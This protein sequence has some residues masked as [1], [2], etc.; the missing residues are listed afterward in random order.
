[1]AVARLAAD[2]LTLRE[3]CERLSVS[4][5]TAKTHLT[6]VYA[7]LGVNNRAQLARFFLEKHP[8]G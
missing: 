1:M 2:G 3:I 6:H 8:N 7:K 4:P 5:G